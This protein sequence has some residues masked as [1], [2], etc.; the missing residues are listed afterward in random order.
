VHRGAKCVY[1]YLKEEEPNINLGKCQE[2]IKNCLTCKLYNPIKVKGTRHVQAYDVG[3]MVAIDVVGP[4]ENKYIVTG[5]D[6]FSRYGFVK[7][8]PDRNTE[9]IIAFLNNIREKINIKTLISDGSK[10]MKSKLISD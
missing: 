7:I 4:Y 5:I 3:E 1:E 8:I 2:A 10:E 6:Y 9:N